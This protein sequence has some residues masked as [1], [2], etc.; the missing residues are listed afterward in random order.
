MYVANLGNYDVLPYL[1]IRRTIYCVTG[2]IYYI[3]YIGIAFRVTV[4]RGY[5]CKISLLQARL[6]ASDGTI[7][8]VILY[9]VI[10]LNNAT[11]YN[12]F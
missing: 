6:V 11:I 2:N 5:D 7:F 4:S 3:L 10:L 12:K 1:R 8:R 9:Y